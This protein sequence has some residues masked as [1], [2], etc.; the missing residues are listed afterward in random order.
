MEAITEIRHLNPD[1]AG[2]A[3]GLGFPL[4]QMISSAARVRS[5][6]WHSTP[7]LNRRQNTRGA[8]NSSPCLDWQKLSWEIDQRRNH[9]SPQ[10]GKEYELGQGAG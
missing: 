4:A 10:D 5:P 3:T 6:I 1:M 2:A 8:I 9:V 7:T